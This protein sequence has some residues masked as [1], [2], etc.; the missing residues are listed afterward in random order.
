ML[1]LLALS[2]LVFGIRIEKRDVTTVNIKALSQESLK[3]YQAEPGMGLFWENFGLT[4][5]SKSRARRGFQFDAYTTEN[6]GVVQP[7]L[8]T[9]VKDYFEVDIYLGICCFFGFIGFVGSILVLSC[10]VIRDPDRLDPD[11]VRL[12]TKIMTIVFLAISTLLT[13]FCLFVTI[14]SLNDFTTGM[15]NANLAAGSVVTSGTLMLQSGKLDVDSAFSNF[16]SPLRLMDKI[17]TT[18]DADISS[19]YTEMSENSTLIDKKI[20]LTKVARS[21][22]DGLI[23]NFISLN[24]TLYSRSALFNSSLS[25][26]AGLDAPTFN[27]PLSNVYKL[28]NYNPNN[29][30]YAYYH[31]DFPYTDDIDNTSLKR[32]AKAKNQ[33]PA[34]SNLQSN[35]DNLKSKLKTGQIESLDGANA[36]LWNIINSIKASLSDALRNSTDGATVKSQY[37]GFNSASGNYTTNLGPQNIYIYIYLGVMGLLLILTGLF[38]ALKFPRIGMISLCLVL[39][40]TMICFVASFYYYLYA[41]MVGD[42][43]DY[44][45]IQSLKLVSPEIASYSAA[46]VAA[47]DLCDRNASL[48]EILQN[49]TIQ[50]MLPDGF[51][52]DTF[53]ITNLVA[54]AFAQNLTYLNKTFLDLKLS[55]A[56]DK[57]STENF[58]MQLSAM[59]ISGLDPIEILKGDLNSTSATEIQKALALLSNSLQTTTNDIE[60]LSN[61]TGDLNAELADFKGRVNQRISALNSFLSI[62]PELNS[63]RQSLNATFNDLANQFAIIKNNVSKYD[64]DHYVQ[65]IFDTYDKWILKTKNDYDTEFSYLIGNVTNE[66]TM[67]LQNGLKSDPCPNINAATTAMTVSLCNIAM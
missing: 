5:I 64:S 62:Y 19:L 20:D 47:K 6:N 48:S 43:C 31:Q 9:I 1:I 12:P 28:K 63:K 45:N 33:F 51:S 34:T 10:C 22:T 38:I 56:I 41:F 36:S 57:S 46:G 37:E 16:S 21:L 50:K 13:V 32:L 59:N 35:I 42:S 4:I 11:D 14:S 30:T 27:F 26:L 24:G 55:S 65:S 3:K 25:L 17:N 44:V 8:A 40:L 15:N 23:A 29:L 66:L 58:I 7:N 18:V 52:Q 60:D 54:T 67:N 61:P 49:T 53:N 2:L 39:F